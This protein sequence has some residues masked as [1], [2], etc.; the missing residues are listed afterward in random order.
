MTL[1]KHN[2]DHSFKFLNPLER[3]GLVFSNRRNFI[4]AGLAGMGGLTLP[5][6]LRQRAGA[7]NAG[8]SLPGKKAVILLW[9]AGGPSQIDTW[10]PKP[11]RPLQNRGPFA[12]IPTA[13]AGVRFCEHIPKLSPAP[14][15]WLS[16]TLQSPQSSPSIMVLIILPC[17]RMFLFQKVEAMLHMRGT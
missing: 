17:L 9:M 7:A 12:T 15:I 10:D 8:K 2:H 14:T 1:S 13:I 11:D 16:I 3:E 5:D 6:L 4:K